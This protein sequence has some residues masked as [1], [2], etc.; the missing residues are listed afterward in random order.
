MP[1]GLSEPLQGILAFTGIKFA[2]YSLAALYLNKSYPNSNP[3]FLVVG[4]I[5]TIIGIAFGVVLA[6]ISFPFVFVSGLGFLIYFLGLIPIRLLEWL[7]VIRFFYDKGLEDKQKM[8]KN[9]ILGAVWSFLLDIPALLGLSLIC[10][11][12]IC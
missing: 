3:N 12:W 7:I 1:G 9:L 11:F 8:W 6:T 5:R 4:L 2:G 10:N